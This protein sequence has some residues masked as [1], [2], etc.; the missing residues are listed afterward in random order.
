MWRGAQQ[1]QPYKQVRLYIN[2]NLAATAAAA[3]AIGERGAAEVLIS[4]AAATKILF[5]TRYSHHRQSSL[6]QSQISP[7]P[8]PETRPR[9]PHQPAPQ[10]VPLESSPA[11]CR[12]TQFCSSP[13]SS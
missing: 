5:T 2:L 9:S 3:A 1:V 4:A 7:R 10:C 12:S 11:K 13:V 6:C 8:T